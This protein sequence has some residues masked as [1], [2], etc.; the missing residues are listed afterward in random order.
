MTNNNIDKALWITLY[1]SMAALVGCL[2][3]LVAVELGGNVAGALTVAAGILVWLQARP[4]NG[5]SGPE[6]I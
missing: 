6:D 1:L 4:W 3:A 5:M 2:W